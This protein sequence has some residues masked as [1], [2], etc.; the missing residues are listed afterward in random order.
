MKILK[1]NKRTVWTIA[2]VICEKGFNTEST[3]NK[4]GGDLESVKPEAGE[5][6]AH[7]WLSFR[8]QNFWP[9]SYN[10]LQGWIEL[11]PLVVTS[12]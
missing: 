12:S 7:A 11:E 4:T 6:S 8:R 1:K 9:T 2:I 10:I 5:S 3:K